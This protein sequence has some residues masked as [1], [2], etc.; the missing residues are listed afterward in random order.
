MSA[1]LQTNFANQRCK[2]TTFI[3]NCKIMADFFEKGRF[4]SCSEFVL[5]KNSRAMACRVPTFRANDHSS[6][7]IQRFNNQTKKKQEQTFV[8][9]ALV[10]SWRDWLIIQRL[11]SLLCQPF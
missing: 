7:T 3:L 2:V 4:I 10:L 9:S 5:R 8:G 11:F 1:H 6:T